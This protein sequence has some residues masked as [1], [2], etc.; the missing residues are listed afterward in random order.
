[1]RHLLA[2]ALFLPLPALAQDY[3]LGPGDVITVT[4]V[5]EP[6]LSAEGLRLAPGGRVM[7]PGIGT[8]D[9]MG[10]TAEGA[11]DRIAADLQAEQ[12]LTR[13]DVLVEIAA[14][15]PLFV[16]GDVADPGA[17]EYLPGLTV[18]QALS[19]AGGFVRPEP[20]DA[21][22]RIERGRLSLT[23]S[24]GRE[25]LA[26]ALLRRARLLAERDAGPLAAPEE[27]AALVPPDR[28][29]AMLAAEGAL[30]EARAEALAGGIAI[31]TEVQAELDRE[32]EA[33]RAQFDAKDRQLALVRE[34]E[35]KV[36]S[37][38][39]RDLV[40]LQRSLA[41]RNAAIQLEADKL[42]IR[43][44]IS[45]AQT[46]RAKAEQEKGNLRD[47]R[48]LEILAGLQAEEDGIALLS[49]QL[50]RTAAQIAEVDRMAGGLAAV[51]VAATATM[52]AEG[53]GGAEGIVIVRAGRV[54]PAT[55]FD[56]VAPDDV[57]F[58]PFQ[59]AAGGGAAP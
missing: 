57:I 36:L 59:G 8:T 39:E 34:E 38:A 2:L 32:V 16:T 53:E 45:R 6:Q 26:Q 40:S 17:Y 5:E 10:L 3:T 35:E 23:L 15:R 1:M 51:Q 12:G 48:R 56:A 43:A 54:V 13:P 49:D 30:M 18:L 20:A 22:L 11:R 19:L 7:L 47:A 31:L 55:L 25:E 50:A 44:F 46:S 9:L 14:Y 4:V 58:V 41:V 37:L 28:L 21:A 29:A 52:A 33:L 42:E 27:V 24:Q